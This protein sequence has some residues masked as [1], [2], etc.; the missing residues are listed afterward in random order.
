MTKKEERIGEENKKRKRRRRAEDKTM[1]VCLNAEIRRIADTTLLHMFAITSARRMGTEN[2]R[3]MMRRDA[4]RV[5]RI[6]SAT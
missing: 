1:S 6:T 4:G 3:K 2:G 5:Q